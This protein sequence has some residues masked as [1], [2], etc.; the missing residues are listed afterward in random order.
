MLDAKFKRYHVEVIDALDDDE[1]IEKE[2]DVMEEHEEK[3]AYIT[4]SLKS[5]CSSVPT[6]SSET[7]APIKT[8][9][10]EQ[11]VLRR[12][13]SDL[14]MNARRINSKITAVIPGPSMDHCLLEQCNRQIA[15]FE[16][17]M[18]DLSRTIATMEDTS[19][20]NNE[21][22]QISDVIFNLGLKINK[23]LSYRKEATTK[24]VREEI[25]LPKIAVPTIDGDPLK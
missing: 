16:T 12:C 1:E 21:K 19:E 2:A 22:L 3:M 9:G 4:I 5:I 20:L 14:E 24:P 18:L 25:R 23:F 10:K 8:E 17:K 15:G 6:T 11:E 13:L 7:K